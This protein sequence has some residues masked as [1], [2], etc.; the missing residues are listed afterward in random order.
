MLLLLVS[1]LMMVSCKKK[2]DDDYDPPV[3]T[4][5]LLCDGNGTNSYYPLQTGNSYTYSYKLKSNAQKDKLFNITKDTV[6]A[7]QTYK[8]LQK[9]TMVTVYELLRSDI[10]NNIYAYI[11]ALNKEVLLVPGTPV[12]DQVTGATQPGNTAKVTSIAAYFSTAYCNYSSLLE[13]TEFDSKGKAVAVYQYKQGVGRVHVGLA[14]TPDATE[15]YQ[16]KSLILK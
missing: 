9:D 5:T 13:I 16:L 8:K 7:G 11:P 14:P 4:P 6:V 2:K 12:F 1:T 10:S 3:V 15:D